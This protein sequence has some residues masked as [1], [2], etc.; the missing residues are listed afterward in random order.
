MWSRIFHSVTPTIGAVLLSFAGIALSTTAA[1]GQ[2]Q[3][4]AATEYSDD[5]IKRTARVYVGIR[6]IREEYQRKLQDIDN[7]ARAAPLQRERQKKIDQLLSEQ[8]LSREQYKKITAAAQ[9]DRE[10][11]KRLRTAIDSVE[12]E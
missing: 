1:H 4:L 5:V 2:D 9:S 10:L 8:N 7:P 11:Y 12:R 3:A 6:D